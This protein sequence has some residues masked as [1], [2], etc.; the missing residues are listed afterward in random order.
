MVRQD[1]LLVHPFAMIAYSRSERLTTSRRELNLDNL[2]CNRQ[3]II[4]R[5]D[6]VQLAGADMYSSSSRTC[7]VELLQNL[8]LFDVDRD[9]YGPI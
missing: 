7:P 6:A 3:H 9:Q 1:M 2:L 5:P 8:D 4:G